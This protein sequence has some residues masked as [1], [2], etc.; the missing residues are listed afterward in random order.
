[1][2]APIIPAVRS[3]KSGDRGHDDL[4][5]R[6]VR[7]NVERTVAQI[8]SSRPL[9]AGAVKEGRVKVVGG[10]YDLATGVVTFI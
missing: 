4:L 6:A 10:V 9:V 8:R 7:A 1:M 3:V 5:N 2:V